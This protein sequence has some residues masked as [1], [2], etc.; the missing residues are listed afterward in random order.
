MT[1]EVTQAVFHAV[2]L[3]FKIPSNELVKKTETVL[4][5]LPPPTTVT[6]SRGGEIN[7]LWGAGEKQ[8]SISFLNTESFSV[9]A[10]P[11][12]KSVR[13]V[14]YDE[15]L[16]KEVYELINYALDTQDGDK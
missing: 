3:G 11:I 16:P 8:T 15:T 1:N 14:R 10:E 7:C 2:R 4:S 9:V 13:H 5:C 12:G 6:A